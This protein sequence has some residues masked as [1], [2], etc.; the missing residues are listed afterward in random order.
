MVGIREGDKARGKK[1]RPAPIEP[2]FYR[3]NM[4]L[5]WRPYRLCLRHVTRPRHSTHCYET[6]GA[7][8][9]RSRSTSALLTPGLYDR[10][11]ERGRCCL[12]CLT[13]SAILSFVESFSN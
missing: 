6:L 9:H 4:P 12:N 10:P 3:I 13:I 7:P 5:K 11:A 8:D 2:A 1:R